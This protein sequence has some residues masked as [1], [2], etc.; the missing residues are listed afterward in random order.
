MAETRTIE[1]RCQCGRPVTFAD[2][3][4]PMCSECRQVCNECTCPPVLAQADS[5]AAIPTGALLEPGARLERPDLEGMQAEFTASQHQYRTPDGYRLARVIAYA[6][7][8]EQ[9]AA[10]AIGRL[11]RELRTKREAFKTIANCRLNSGN[12]V[13]CRACWRLAAHHERDHTA[14]PGAVSADEARE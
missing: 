10:G 4:W 6:L 9:D 2:P 5:D 12:G 3:A 14:L 8:V 13:I 7:Q 1:F 11:E